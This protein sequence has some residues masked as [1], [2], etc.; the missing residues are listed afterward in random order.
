M[1]SQIGTDPLFAFVKLL[2][3][4][5]GPNGSTTFTDQS[6]SA[7]TLTA[8]GNAQIQSS[9]LD[10][11]GSG[12]YVSSPDSAD[13]VLTGDFCLEIFGVVFD[14]IASGSTLIAQYES[15]SSRRSWWFLYSGNLSPK[16]FQLIFSTDGGAVTTALHNFT[17]VAGVPYAICVE[18]SGTTV[19]LYVNGV[20]IGS[21]TYGSTTFNTT[22]PL[23][24]GAANPLSTPSNFLDG[25]IGAVRYTQAAR[26]ASDSGYLVPTLPL[27]AS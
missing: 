26:Y 18:R 19:R 4:F 11:D 25:K 21:S 3:Q 14:N 6:S 9:K 12:D 17:A 20:M 10:L 1:L 22:A 7:H 15:I 23:T 27:P 13:W 24:I 2:A 8:L 16:R 5:T